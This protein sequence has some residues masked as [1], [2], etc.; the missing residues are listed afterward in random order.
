MGIE[1]GIIARL[2]AVTA[3]TDLVSNRIYADILPD[4]ESHPAIVY[5]LISTIPYSSLND[6]TGIL[7]SRMQFTLIADSKS[8]SIQL[9]DA[10]KTALQRF[11]GVVSDVTIHDSKIENIFDQAYDDNTDQTARIADFLITYE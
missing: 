1:S 11:K 2:N 6:D 10:M 9:S 3:I 8:A 5:Q 7:V 4:N